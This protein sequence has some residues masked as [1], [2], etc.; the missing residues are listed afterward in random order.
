MSSPPSNDDTEVVCENGICYK[1][2]KQNVAA[3]AESTESNSNSTDSS[4]SVSGQQVTIDEKLSH[5]KEL[6]EKKRKEKDEEDA[7]V[8]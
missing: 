3:A 5:A 7:R 4:S 8:S 6:I 1:R 2:P